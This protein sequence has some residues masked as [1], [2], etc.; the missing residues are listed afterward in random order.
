MEVSPPRRHVQRNDTRARDGASPGRSTPAR[1][2]DQLVRLSCRSWSRRPGKCPER[3]AMRGSS[4]GWILPLA[5]AERRFR[6]GKVAER[7][8]RTVS[9]SASLLRRRPGA[10]PPRPHRRTPWWSG[11]HEVAALRSSGSM[12]CRSSRTRSSS[13]GAL[14]KELV[15]R[16]ASRS[17]STSTGALSKM[18]RSKRGC[19][20]T[21]FSSHRR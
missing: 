11:F 19:N 1:H 12:A 8:G 6:F 4:R 13:P 2:A 9:G 20:R 15:L 21:W 16:E 5:D 17:V 14:P 3:Y 18:I 7:R 10:R